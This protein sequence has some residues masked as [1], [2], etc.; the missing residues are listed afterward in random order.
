MEGRFALLV[1]VSQYGD[2][3]EPLPGSEKDL[4]QIAQVLGNPDMGGFEVERLSN[5]APQKLREKI[6]HFFRNRSRDDVLLFY[7][8]GHGVLDDTGSRLYLSTCE[9][10]KENQQFVPSSAV[11]ATFLRDQLI[12]SKSTQKI[13][14]LDCCFSGAVAN[15]LHK[16]DSNINLEPL[17]AKGS[18]ILASCE[19]YE[20]SYQSKEINEDDSASSLYT[21][22]LVEGIRTGAARDG[23]NEWIVARNLHE[24]AQRC[25]HTE[26]SASMQPRIITLDRE[27][28]EIRVAKVRRDPKIEFTQIVTKRLEETDGKIERFTTFYFE[29]ERKGLGLSPDSAKAII[30]KQRIPYIIRQEKRDEYE[31]AFIIAL[32]EGI[33]PVEREVLKKIQVRL[34]LRDEDVLAIEAKY[35]G[36]L[37]PPPEPPV[38][39]IPPVAPPIGNTASGSEATGVIAETPMR[40]PISPPGKVGVIERPSPPQPPQPPQLD[41]WKIIVGITSALVGVITLLQFYRPS[42]LKPAQDLIS[43]GDNLELY[44]SRS[45][46]LSPELQQQKAEG[47][48]A[49]RSG[50]YQKAY[51]IFRDI[52]AKANR[53]N[54]SSSPFKDPEILIF[55]NNAQARLNSSKPNG[56][57]VLTIAATVP[58][59]DTQG[60][61]LIA[62]GQQMLFGVALAQAQAQAFQ[63]GINLE[64]MIANDLNDPA[65]AKALAQVLVNPIVGSDGISRSILAVIGHYSS[66]TTCAALATYSQAELAV[67]SP[68]ATQPDLRSICAGNTFFRTTSSIPIE[69]KTLANYLV[70]ESQ[71]PK[72]KVAIFY[73]SKEPSVDQTQ[74]VSS[75]SKTMSASL[76]QAL[77]TQNIFTFEP[78]DLSA[79]D[80]DAQDALDRVREANVLAIFPDGKVGS[81]E[82]VN[83]AIEVM[84]ADGG[85]RLILG[86]NTLAEQ[87]PI[88]NGNAKQVTVQA[89]GI[90]FLVA[91]DWSDKCG[92]AQKF[93]KDGGSL[94]GGPPTRI[95]A[96]AT[97]A[98]QAVTFRLSQ[99]KTTQ[100][101]ILEDLRSGSSLSSDVFQD[102]TIS[103]EPNGD[104]REIASR[105]LVTSVT[106]KDGRKQFA[107]AP[108][109]SCPSP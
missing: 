42:Q 63:D 30:D 24:Y 105:I 66:P 86:A 106:G 104:R 52:R 17:K 22:Y 57:P 83:R 21:R 29:V 103:F 60:K 20:L 73:N 80:F 19:S 56:K 53:D 67:I 65:Q 82:A 35:A 91:V 88:E 25:F 1:G 51:D 93:I 8:S 27:G 40:E 36:S 49:F 16:G 69:I 92:G 107:L 5:P 15:L 38:P 47:I 23:N 26:Q 48:K 59:S 34:S 77:N 46:I 102:K 90:G 71:I 44:G 31:A 70:T 28:Y 14:V 12:N 98:T 72:P 43:V 76:Q 6:D 3:F 100:Q 96:L 99:G 109:R 75:Y 79:E 33:S 68:T 41:R 13:V 58:V 101:D 39:P 95:F 61:Q 85:Q 45:S 64:V 11:E 37:P 32:E 2:G 18:V 54:S 84:K 10:Q 89:P 81:D 97:E 55:Q 108:G 4:E 94:W 7:F 74:T 87:N 50:D 62:Y 9:T 78:I